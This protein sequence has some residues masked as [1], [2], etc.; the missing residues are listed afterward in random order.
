M[1]KCESGQMKA[2]QGS[3]LQAEWLENSRKAELNG[4]LTHA[5]TASSIYN[6]VLEN[7]SSESWLTRNHVQCIKEKSPVSSLVSNLFTKFLAAPCEGSPPFCCV[8]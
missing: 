6:I 2:V 5:M 8:R 1:Q 4:H 3:V 7:S